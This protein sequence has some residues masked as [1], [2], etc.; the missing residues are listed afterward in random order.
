MKNL[1]ELDKQELMTTDGG[2]WDEVVEGAVAGGMAGSAI[3]GVGTLGGALVGA[4]IGAIF[5]DW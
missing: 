4:A 3:P 2:G 1:Q 5:S